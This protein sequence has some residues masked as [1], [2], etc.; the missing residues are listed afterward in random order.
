M[1]VVA[2]CSAGV[3]LFLIGGWATKRAIV[4]ARGLAKIARPAS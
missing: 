2:V 4:E 3:V 1:T